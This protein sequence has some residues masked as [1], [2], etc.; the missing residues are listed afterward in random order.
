MTIL[1]FTG[2]VDA[3]ASFCDRSGTIYTPTIDG[4][5]I[6]EAIKQA[7]FHRAV[8]VG[9]ADERF[10]GDLWAFNASPGYSEYTPAESAELTVGPHNL[11][12][13]LERHAGQ[14]V[15][16]WIADEPFNVLE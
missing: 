10:N 6:I 11:I 1:K 5:D 13:I 8:T 3:E 12:E 9:L 4:V 2:L 14:T 15:T 16:L 7:G